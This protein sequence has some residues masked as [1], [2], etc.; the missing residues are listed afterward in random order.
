MNWSLTQKSSKEKENLQPKREQ[1]LQVCHHHRANK[2][3]V[4]LMLTALITLL[5]LLV[6]NMEDLVV[7]ILIRLAI[8]RASSTQCTIHTVSR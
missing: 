8:K 4:G 6:E 2:T 1:S 7:K 3:M 5:P